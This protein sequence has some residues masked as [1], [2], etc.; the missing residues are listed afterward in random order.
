MIRIIVFL[1]VVGALALG[2]AWLADRPGDVIVTWPWLEQVWPGHGRNE[3]SLLVLGG[4]ILIAMAG[5]AMLWGIIRAI[6]RSPTAFANM[7]RHRRGVRAYEAISGGLIAV[8]SGDVEAAQRHASDDQAAGAERTACAVALRAIGPACR[9][10]RRRRAHLSRYGGPARHQAARTAW[11]V[12]RGA[13]PQR[14]GKRAGLRRRSGRDRAVAGLGR[15]GG[16]GSA[17][18]GRRLGR[19]AGASGGECGHAR[20]DALSAAARR[21]AHRPRPCRRG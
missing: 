1:V 8:G 3:V 7:R 14:S 2:V 4:V 20:Q 17:M 9:R 16:T 5:L 18:Q 19:C 21:A 6:M 10:P 13:S 15:P 12:Y 11:I